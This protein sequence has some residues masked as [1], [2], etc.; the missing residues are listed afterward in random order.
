MRSD[1]YTKTVLT[2]IMLLLGVVALR[3]LTSPEPPRRLRANLADSTSPVVREASGCSTTEPVMHGFMTFQGRLHGMSNCRMLATRWSRSRAS[4]QSW[5]GESASARLGLTSPA[6]SRFRKGIAGVRSPRLQRTNAG[7]PLT[8]R[9]PRPEPRT[10]T[11]RGRG[12]TGGPTACSASNG[13]PDQSCLSYT[14][15]RARSSRAD[16]G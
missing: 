5:V 16:H 7:W 2:A 8:S 1:L 6:H 3:P 4:P 15:R 10:A 9:S 13:C 12:E 14:G 11:R